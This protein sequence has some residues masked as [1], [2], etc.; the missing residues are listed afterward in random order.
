MRSQSLGAGASGPDP[1]GECGLLGVGIL[2]DAAGDDSYVALRLAQGAAYLGVGLLVD[3][4]GDDTYRGH[5]LVQGA[6][7]F[8]AG[9]LVD[10]DGDDRYEAH[11]L[12]QA[13]GMPGGAGLLADRRGDDRYYAKGTHPTSYG[14]PG[15]FEGWSQGCGVGFRTLASGGFALLHDGGGRDRFEAGNFSQGGGYYYGLGVLCA[16]GDEDDLYVGSRYAQGFAAHQAVG[17]FVDEGGGDRYVTRHAVGQGLAWDECVSLFVDESGDD[18]YDGGDSFSQ[19]ASAHNSIAVFWDRR[20]AD[21]YLS[22]PSLGQAGGNDYHG[23]TSLSVFIDEGGDRDTY[24]GAPIEGA[25][26][27]AAGEHG[28]VA[29]LPG[30]LAAALAGER[31]DVPRPRRLY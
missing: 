29:D 5:A 19:G 22:P 16:G 2:L 3:E 28:I 24:A 8:G 13:V 1:Q 7:L 23:G 11:V 6:G 18:V 31:E 21:R 9:L 14:T 20:G 12:A 17:A 25:P 26:A 10:R 27:H 30:T 15:V 4:E